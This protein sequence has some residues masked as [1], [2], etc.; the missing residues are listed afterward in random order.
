[1]GGGGNGE[2]F[3]DHHR[4]INDTDQEEW[5]RKFLYRILSYRFLDTCPWTTGSEQSISR[6]TVIIYRPPTP[7]LSDDLTP[8]P[9]RAFPWL[10]VREIRHLLTCP[11][12]PPAKTAAGLMECLSI[13]CYILPRDSDREADKGWWGVGGMCQ[14]SE[15]QRRLCHTA[16]SSGQTSPSSSQCDWLLIILQ[17]GRLR[18]TAKFNQNTHTHTCL[19]VGTPLTFPWK[20]P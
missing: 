4:S 15:T 2:A 8:I 6:R 11:H 14:G 7:H 19:H 17:T 3:Q 20:N 5:T 10:F 16:E 18:R 13:T 1:M 12:T 9:W